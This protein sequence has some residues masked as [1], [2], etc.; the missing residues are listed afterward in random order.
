MIRL[1]IEQVSKQYERKRWALKEI[2]LSLQAGTIGLV[3]PNG[4]GKTT[5]LMM[6]ATLLAPT[7]GRV[8]WNGIDIYKQPKQAR[9]VLGFMPQKIA[10]YPNLTAK[11]FLHFIG[12]LKGL[13]GKNLHKQVNDCLE[14]VNLIDDANQRL[15]SFSGGMLQRVGIAQALLNDPRLLLLDEPT[16]GL[17]PTERIHFREII[18]SL[19]G[20]RLVI[21][22]THIIT[23]I[24]AMANNLILLQKGRVRWEGNIPEL[25]AKAEGAVWTAQMSVEEFERLR[26]THQIS[27]AMKT[28][29]NRME[30]RLVTDIQP[31]AGAT[32]VTPT[33]EEAYLLATSQRSLAADAEVK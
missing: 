6:L 20:E 18:A 30:A 23:D 24:E 1:D 9:Q 3:G 22:S 33:L 19:Q 14:M 11:E 5:L 4:A 17:D 10:V 15:K 12:E 8:T 32:L 31:I 7:T 28:S 16:E 25:I 27:S 26:V 2:S 13:Y 29:N 21:I